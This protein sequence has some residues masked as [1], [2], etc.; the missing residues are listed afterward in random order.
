M[1]STM[2]PLN[3][4]AQRCGAARGVYHRVARLCVF[5]SVSLS[6]I[7][8][9]SLSRPVVGRQYEDSSP[10]AAFA[11]GRECARCACARECMCVCDRGNAA[12][13]VWRGEREYVSFESFV[14]YNCPMQRA[15]SALTAPSAHQSSFHQL[16]VVPWVVLAGSD[17]DL[18]CTGPHSTA[19]PIPQ[20][21]VTANTNQFMQHSIHP[22]RHQSQKN[23]RWPD[24]EHKG[25]RATRPSTSVAAVE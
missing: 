2:G 6:Y 21:V 13:V 25:S 16:R 18:C 19:P 10:L 17:V 9:P 24:K 1:A 15:T 4:L 3:G 23:L 20:C 7:A 22:S 14:P 5:M 8:C 12:W 11:L